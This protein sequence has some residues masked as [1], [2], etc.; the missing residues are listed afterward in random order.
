MADIPTARA[1]RLKLDDPRVVKKYLDNLHKFF[2]KH[3]IYKRVE[4]LRKEWKPGRTLTRAQAK[5]Y[6]EID[7]IREKGMK[8]A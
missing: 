4:K 3:R 5:E 7:T 2:K 6:E 1:R 8:A